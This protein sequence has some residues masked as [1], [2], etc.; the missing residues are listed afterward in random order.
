MS[1]NIE[2]GCDIFDD[3]RQKLSLKGSEKVS[4][5]YAE[6]SPCGCKVGLAQVTSPVNSPQDQHQQQQEIPQLFTL[7]LEKNRNLRGLD[8]PWPP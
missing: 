3:I 4:Q 8:V 5:Y 7:T 6:F 1:Q 2:G